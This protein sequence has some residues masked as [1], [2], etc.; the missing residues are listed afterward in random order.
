MTREI[1]VKVVDFVTPETQAHPLLIDGVPVNVAVFQKT[2]GDL[3]RFPP[4]AVGQ[5]RLHV[6]QKL[7]LVIDGEKVQ[8]QSR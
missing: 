8:L 1:W 3:K 7:K 2:G 4:V 5:Q 6:G